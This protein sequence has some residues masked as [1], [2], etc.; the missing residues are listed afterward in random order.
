LR[1]AIVG[2]IAQ[3]KYQTSLGACRNDAEILRKFLNATKAYED[4]C[5]LGPETT[6]VEAKKLIAEFIQKYRSDKIDELFVYFSGHGDRTEDDF[7]YAMSDYKSE[8]RETTG[9]RNSELDSLIRNLSPD[10]TI[11]IVDACY[12]GSTYIKAEDDITP[13]IQKSAK[14]NQLKKLYFFYSSA[15]DQTSWAGRQFSFFTLA[16]FQSLADQN[17]PVRYRDLMAALADEMNR[18]AA[19]APTFVVQA[20]SLE[21]FVQMDATLSD[22]LKSAIGLSHPT[23]TGSGAKDSEGEAQI[24]DNLIGKLDTPQ[25][26]MSLA[27][28]AALKASETYC[29]E[30]EAKTNILLMEALLAP[31]SWPEEIRDAYDFEVREVDPEDVP[32]KYAIAKWISALKEDSVFAIPTFEKEAYTVE[33]YKELPKKP[34]SQKSFWGLTALAQTRRILGDDQDKEYK[35]ESVKKTREVLSG[36]SYTVDP[37][38]PPRIITLI[39]KASSLEQYAACVVCLF[40]RRTLTC[41][42]SVEHLPYT[43]W[44]RTQ[45]PGANK[46]KQLSAPLKISARIN[47]LVATIIAE[48]SG[49]VE[50]DARQRLS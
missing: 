9:L 14:E 47:G 45:P 8:R 35:L 43:G 22:L 5:F 31:E 19:P 25:Q 2:G 12:S 4:V 36:F 6:G 24:G 41:L 21:I 42:Y 46:W 44:T 20:D 15:A 34:Q 7:F 27:K 39:P 48:I 16:L 1:L 50:A 40:S 28:L 32:N 23:L 13:I 10:L 29:T 11:K 18:Q 17:G 3:Y 26:P 37:V 38:F 30:D 49:F 33:E